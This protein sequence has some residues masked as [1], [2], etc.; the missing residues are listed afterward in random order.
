MSPETS[1]KFRL[2]NE[3]DKRFPRAVIHRDLQ[4]QLQLRWAR[5]SLSSLANLSKGSD[6]I[7]S[8][9]ENEPPIGDTRAARL[10]KR[11]AL[12]RSSDNGAGFEARQIA[13]ANLK[14][15][16]VQRHTEPWNPDCV[17][18]VDQADLDQ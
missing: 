3:R 13:I 2:L 11:T 4:L 14:L 16:R 5:S 18:A 10:S 8:L 7:Q 12:Y 6:D 9:R 15:G 17:S 1:R